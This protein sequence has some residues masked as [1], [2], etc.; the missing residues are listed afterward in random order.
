LYPPIARFNVIA[1]PDT[2][3][4][5]DYFKIK[6]IAVDDQDQEV[7]IDP[8]CRV[9]L[10]IKPDNLLGLYPKTERY[11]VMRQGYE[12]Y[13]FKEPPTGI[14]ECRIETV[15]ELGWWATGVGNVTI[16]KKQAFEHFKV[17]LTKD[18][19]KNREIAGIT[20]TAVDINN[21][22]VSLDPSTPIN[23]TFEDLNQYV[24]FISAEGDTVDELTDVPYGTL[25]QGL[26]KVIA[27]GTQSGP[28]I[29]SVAN[30]S[31]GAI[32][33]TESGAF[34][35]DF[36][37]TKINAVMVTDVLKLGYCD[38]I[39]KPEIKVI[40][41]ADSIKP[42]YPTRRDII[43]VDESRTD[44]KVVVTLSGILYNLSLPYDIEIASFAVEGSG[45]HSHD[46]DR[47]TGRFIEENVEHLTLQ[48]VTN[49]YDKI[50]ISGIFIWRKRE[51]NC[52]V[53]WINSCYSRY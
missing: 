1:E 31:I 5:G 13:V 32:I 15:S 37:S 43:P 22:E 17:T 21:N 46:G 49:G 30:R 7:S 29:A 28:V 42:N 12:I 53:S 25:R 48:K 51:N 36:P 50:H 14:Q 20:I 39:L 6:V 44:V 10:S 4:K 41:V 23:L 27:R 8:S 24:D 38:L 26:V 52:P 18:T 2:V 40:A 35:T 3:Y 33:A 16:M 19:L 9:L 11:G 47:P 34:R 45:G